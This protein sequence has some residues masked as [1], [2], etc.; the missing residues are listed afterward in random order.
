MKNIISYSIKAGV[1]PLMVLALAGCPPLSQSE[2]DAGYWDGFMTDSK[3]WEGYADSYDTVPD[4]PILYRGSEIPYLE[5]D[6]YDAGYYDGLWY[7]YNDGYFV[8]YDYGF[9]IGFSEGYD[10][11]YQPGWIAFLLNDAHP[12][13][14]D[15]SFIDGYND[16]FS[17]G[18]VFG[19]ADYKLGL[20][21]DWEDA[22]WDYR[23]GTDLYLDEVGFGTGEYGIVYLYEYGT[24]PY[25]F[26]T[27]S[28]DAES[29]TSRIRTPRSE[30]SEVSPRKQLAAEST[31]AKASKELE[32][33]QISYRDLPSSVRSQLSTRPEYSQRYDGRPLTLTD[34]WLQ[35][36]ERY[37][38]FRQ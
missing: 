14:L 2:Y 19:A 36:V 35:R 17:E 22:M 37:R 16:G 26:Y 11:G 27:K 18:S 30:A 28:K 10:V 33:G 3:Y 4:G 12:E 9:T 15:G 32:Q 1:I 13:Y 23:G 34:T 21:F 29:R 6:T 8:S 20:V 24:D 7:A 38:A 5:T 25:E 31:A